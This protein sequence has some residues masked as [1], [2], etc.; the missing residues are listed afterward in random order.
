M[1][2]IK[3]TKNSLRAEEKRLDLL[4]KYLP[5][6][7]L[8]K[9]LLQMEVQEAKLELQT[10]KSEFEKLYKDV[11][12]FSA[13]FTDIES[14][15]LQEA[16]KIQAVE[17][18]YDNIAGVEVPVFKNIEF[19]PFEYSLFEAPVW[20]DPAI[21]R[22]RKVSE[23][24]ARLEIAEEKKQALEKELR[25]VSIRVNLFEKV[26]IPEA[27]A[28]I[29][30]IKVFLGDQDLAAVARAKKAKNKIEQRKLLSKLKSVH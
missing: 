24:K 6:L 30:K 11:Q 27:F 21:A 15:D 2:D 12:S 19:A 3:L 8:K 9:A 25:E 22:M 1:A 10:L 26:L 28:N 7:Q 4:K 29:K 5:T 13:L 14:I 18:G 16:A 20:V 23:Q 17:K